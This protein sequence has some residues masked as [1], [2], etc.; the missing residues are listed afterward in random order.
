M[1]AQSPELKD[2]LL[3]SLLECR[4]DQESIVHVEVGGHLQQGRKDWMKERRRNTGE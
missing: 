2:F 3:I 4:E 1:N